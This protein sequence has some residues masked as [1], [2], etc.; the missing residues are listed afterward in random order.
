MRDKETILTNHLRQQN[1]RVFADPVAD[2]VIVKR[3]L[4][5]TGPAHEPT[6]VARGE[7]VRV[8]GTKIAW[9]I[10]R[11]VGNHH[12]HRHAAARDRRIK[13]V[14]V[15]HADTRTAGENARATR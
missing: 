9:R 13:F 8:L 4:G 5:V 15:L 3:F 10:K 7:R 11:A 14:A 1:T 6:H 2:Y 12:L